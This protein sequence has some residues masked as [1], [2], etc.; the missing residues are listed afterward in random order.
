MTRTRKE[1]LAIVGIGCRLPGGVDDVTSFWNLLAA[2]EDAITEIAADPWDVDA[3]FDHVDPQQRLLLETAHRAM[4]DAGE[5]PE[6][7]AG[8]RTGVFVGVN[9]HGDRHLQL[10]NRVSYAFDLRGPSLAVDT[11]CSSS[12]VAIHLSLWRGEST[13]ALA[14]GVNVLVEVEMAIAGMVLVKPLS[15]AR[16]DRNPIYALIRGTAIGQDG[17]APGIS[18][19]SE[20]AQQ[21]LVRAALD[22]AG[23]APANVQYMEAHGTGTLVGDPIEAKALGTVLSEGRPDDRPCVVGSVK[24]SLGHTESA[25]GVASLIKVALAL[26]Q[27]QIPRDHHFV[28]PNPKIDLAALKLRPPQALEPWPAADGPRVAGVNSFGLG[29]THA[30]VV[31]EEAPPAEAP[32]TSPAHRAELLTLSARSLGALLAQADAVRAA[33]YA[34]DFAL[35]DACYTAA[36]RR[37]HHPHR[38]AVIGRSVTEVADR[39]GAFTAGRTS[40]G[41]V[42]GVERTPAPRPIFVFSGMGRQ[43]WAMGRELLAEEPTFAAE[44]RRVDGALRTLAGWS[45]WDVLTASEARSQIHETRFAQAAIFAVQMGLCALWRSW[46]IEPAAIVGHGV[47]EVAAACASGALTLEDA[48]RVI[49][50]RSRLH[51]ARMDPIEAELKAWLRELAPQAPRVPL[52]STVLGR[53]ITGPD[54]DADYWWRNVRHPVYFADALGALVDELDPASAPILIEIGPHP[55]LA[56][57]MREVLADRRRAG[58]V[59]CSLHRRQPERATLLEALGTLYGAGAA[60]RWEAVCPTGA[61]A[62]LP[63]YPWRRESYW[64]ELAT[65]RIAEVSVRLAGAR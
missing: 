58:T 18:V 15:A 7:L 1:P 31:L 48:A 35:A 34:G 24:T 16:R 53:R 3:L 59:V 17:R 41:L 21:R 39:L 20:L 4:E 37:S 60:I 23:V 51:G 62:P 19:P 25:S 5:V 54:L 40:P 43:W 44:I 14:G 27:R 57:S 64:P 32:T 36:L 45:L 9:I 22:D 52:Y 46:G 42:A 33:L 29:G 47:G 50:Q 11:A 28:E 63:Y 55:V 10:A 61:V 26:L 12:L 2:G 65:E 49:Y 13:A 38:L 8:S 56:T 30:H 6:A